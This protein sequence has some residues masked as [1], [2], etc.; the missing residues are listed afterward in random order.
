MWIINIVILKRFCLFN[1]K[2]VP[3]DIMSKNLSFN[4]N[5]NNKIS[6]CKIISKKKS[7]QTDLLLPIQY[8]YNNELY[9]PWLVLNK[10]GGKFLHFS[11]LDAFLAAVQ[12]LKWCE[13]CHTKS[14]QKYQRIPAVSGNIK[15]QQIT[16]ELNAYIICISITIIYYIIVI[17]M[18]IN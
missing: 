1:H 18:A 11:S 13:L 2:W 14:N 16:I 7:I 17:L 4:I 6:S 3:N 15:G 9:I 8:C 5:A 12:V 10:I